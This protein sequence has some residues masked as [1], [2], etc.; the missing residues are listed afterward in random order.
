MLSSALAE[1]IIVSE[2]DKQISGNDEGIK[3]KEVEERN[4]SESLIPIEKTKKEVTVNNREK[5]QISGDA[6]SVDLKGAEGITIDKELE[7]ERDASKTEK[8]VTVEKSKEVQESA[9]G[10]KYQVM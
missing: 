6:E 5:M 8:E 2:E 10:E 9:T 4:V 1:L 3:K 7:Q